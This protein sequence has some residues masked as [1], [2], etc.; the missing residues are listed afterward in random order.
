MK[1]KKTIFIILGVLVLGF[2]IW[3]FGIRKKELVVKLD[4]EKP[5]IGYI[6]EN[7]TATGRVEPMDTVMVGSL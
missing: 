6:S 5:T 4:T 7:V 3:Y 2:A 1:K